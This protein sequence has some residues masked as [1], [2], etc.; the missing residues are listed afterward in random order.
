M[1]PPTLL[2]CPVI[3]QIYSYFIP[4]S[5]YSIFA[6][7]PFMYGSVQVP[8][9]KQSALM[10]MPDLNLPDLLSLLNL[11]KQAQ[12]VHADLV[13]P[14]LV[15]FAKTHLSAPPTLTVD[16]TIPYLQSAHKASQAQG[17]PLLLT[18]PSLSAAVVASQSTLSHLAI[19]RELLER[20]SSAVNSPPSSGSHFCDTLL[21]SVLNAKPS[22]AFIR[23]VTPDL[24]SLL[25]FLTKYN[26]VREPKRSIS[27]ISNSYFGCYKV[28]DRLASFQVSRL[29]D[30]DYEGADNHIVS[31][32]GEVTVLL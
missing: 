19:S 4:S 15:Y 29:D 27:S 32:G 8:I 31:E 20:A 21:T 22:S 14:L 9:G 30:G 5:K 13:S 12:A 17:T 7:H 24:A 26:L 11:S 28:Y 6:Y 3:S 18:V 25:T 2:D 10:Y 16:L 23:H 1:I